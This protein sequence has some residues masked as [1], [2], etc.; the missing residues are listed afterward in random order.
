MWLVSRPCRPYRGPH[1]SIDRSRKTALELYKRSVEAA[2][3]KGQQGGGLSAWAVEAPAAIVCEMSDAQ[4]EIKDACAKV[5]DS[6]LPEGTHSVAAVH[7]SHG[8]G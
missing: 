7:A 2:G 6:P 5:G 8:G 4:T 3:Q 1:W